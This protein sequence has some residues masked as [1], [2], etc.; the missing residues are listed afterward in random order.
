MYT[1][2]IAKKFALDEIEFNR[3][4]DNCKLEHE[5]TMI[6]NVVVPDELVDSYVALFYDIKAEERRK[7]KETQ[8]FQNAMNEYYINLRV[9]EQKAIREM[10]VT[11]GYNF[12]GFR[13]KKY[14]NLVHGE[15]VLGT[16]FLTELS[17]SVNDFLGAS[18]GAAEG[19][20]SKAK[21]IVE[22]QLIR[23][24]VEKGA[25]A[26]IGVDFDVSTLYNNMIVVSG[27]AT[28]VVIENI[29]EST[30]GYQ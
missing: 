6:G 16:G 9:Q 18:S 19:K 3:F 15:V 24:A 22:N 20:L 27:N 17:V 25:N 12:E 7:E 29:E 1:N 10:M 13:I 26:I 4:L 23:N 8:D 2:E 14:L 30:N 21:R 28:A 11:T 5:V